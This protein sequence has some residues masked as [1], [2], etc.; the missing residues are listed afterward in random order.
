MSLLEFRARE[1]IC[2]STTDL[3]L[4]F[5]HPLLPPMLLANPPNLL[6]RLAQFTHL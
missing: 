1:G 5:P 4:D 3:F 6:R 2:H